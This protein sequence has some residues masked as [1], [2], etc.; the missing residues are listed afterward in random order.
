MYNPLQNTK[1]FAFH[2]LLQIQHFFSCFS[3]FTFWKVCVCVLDV[4]LLWWCVCLLLCSF[5]SMLMQFTKTKPF[6]AESLFLAFDNSGDFLQTF[7]TTC[8]CPSNLPPP[9]STFVLLSFFTNCCKGVKILTYLCCNI[10]GTLWY[11]WNV[12]YV[13]ST[14]KQLQ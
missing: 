13:E 14:A 8:T 3:L 10:H 9:Y 4:Y 6:Q 1:R 2:I 11:N 5:R 7:K 12:D